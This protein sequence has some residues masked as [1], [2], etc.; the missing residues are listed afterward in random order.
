M[1]AQGS[2]EH[3]KKWVNPLNA[4]KINI[5]SPSAREFL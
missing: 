4:T 1:N 2:Y 3:P 5:A